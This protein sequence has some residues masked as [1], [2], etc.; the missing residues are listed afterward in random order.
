METVESAGDIDA[1]RAEA[2]LSRAKDR[3]TSKE[4]VDDTRAKAALQRAVNRL[5][6]SKR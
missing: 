3:M 1:S 5:K 4:D 6:V 2:S